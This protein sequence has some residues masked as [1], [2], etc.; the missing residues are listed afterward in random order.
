[1]RTSLGSTATR[2]RGTQTGS[3]TSPGR[4]LCWV[5]STMLAMPSPI[6]AAGAWFRLVEATSP[7][8]PD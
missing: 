1:M 7:P 2:M 5:N 4:V 6:L 3:S 8:C